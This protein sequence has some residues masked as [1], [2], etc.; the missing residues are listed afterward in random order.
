MES[1]IWNLLHDG[2]LSGVSGSVPGRISLTIDIAYL[3]EF[4]STGGSQLAVT[5]DDCRSFEYRAYDGTAIASASEVASAN[6]ELL[7]ATIEDGAV[8]IECADGGLGGQLTLV[9]ALA[10]VSTA[11]GQM[12]RRS[13]LEEATER[14]WSRWQQRQFDLN[15][16]SDGPR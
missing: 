1:E 9:Y 5:L 12:V 13:D 2:R 10:T 15:S 6:L 7:S 14:Y 11:E 16:R 4:L 3:C 8:S